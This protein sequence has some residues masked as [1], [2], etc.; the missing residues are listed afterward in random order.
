MSNWCSFCDFKDLDDDSQDC[1][2]EE[3]CGEKDCSGGEID[4][5]EIN[6]FA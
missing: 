3:N 2:C 6:E 4:G 5:E 1:T